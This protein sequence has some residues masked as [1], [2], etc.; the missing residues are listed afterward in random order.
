MVDTKESY[1]TGAADPTSTS[2]A[3]RSLAHR[4]L[5]RLKLPTIGLVAMSE[6]QLGYE[7]HRFKINTDS[8]EVRWLGAD[9]L[10]TILEE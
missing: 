1:G 3:W 9:I 5:I 2:T 10:S 8:R 6:A 4:R 7:K